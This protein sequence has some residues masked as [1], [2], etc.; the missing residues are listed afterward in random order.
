[1]NV[2][3]CLTN[4]TYIGIKDVDRL[5]IRERPDFLKENSAGRINSMEVGT[6]STKAKIAIAVGAAAVAFAAYKGYR[7]WRKTRT[8]A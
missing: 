7:Y 2:F 8:A 3:T 5:D 1:M 4:I 6:M